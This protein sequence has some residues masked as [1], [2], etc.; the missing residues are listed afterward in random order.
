MS[1][2]CKFKTLKAPCEG[3]YKEKGSKFF[4]HAFPVQSQQKALEFLEMLRT[5]YHDARHVC[6]AWRLKADAS[7]TRANDAGEPAGT[8]GKPIL[9]Q[10]H[11]FEITNTLV[12]VIRYFGGTKLG[13]GG[14]ISAYK[15]AAALAI[16]NGEIVTILVR[17][18]FRLI[19]K[20]D[21]VSLVKRLNDNLKG[22]TYQEDY[23]EKCVFEVGIPV[24]H[25]DSFTDQLTSNRIEFEPI[26]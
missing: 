15:Q 6:F 19:C 16:E 18:N 21:Q 26:D 12:V 3:L 25:I 22:V 1:E 2:T 5:K 11:S 7:E 9:G 10:L 24:E 23:Q 14:L 4:A 8:A 20:Y 13:V 17:K